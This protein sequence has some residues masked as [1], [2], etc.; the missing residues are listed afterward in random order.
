VRAPW[1]TGMTSAWA[2]PASMLACMPSPGIGAFG[3]VPAHRMNPSAEQCT[4]RPGDSATSP[5][6]GSV[7]RVARHL[8][9][10]ADALRLPLKAQ[11]SAWEVG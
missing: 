6:R 4:S 5:I 11:R 7:L 9:L 10:A 8:A 2:N 1:S 3:R